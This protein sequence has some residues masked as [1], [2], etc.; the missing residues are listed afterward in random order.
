[1]VKSLIK[2]A[3]GLGWSGG[4]ISGEIRSE[5]PIAKG[6]PLRRTAPRDP[7]WVCPTKAS[8]EVRAGK[9]FPE[10]K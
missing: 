9:V 7:P 10:S 5:K 8:F 4:E 1:V 2:P 3:N 6:V